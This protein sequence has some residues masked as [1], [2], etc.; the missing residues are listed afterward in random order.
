[1]TRPAKAC[2]NGVVG[3]ERA[4]R[5][6]GCREPRGQLLANRGQRGEW[7][8]AVRALPPEVA[9]AAVVARIPRRAVVGDGSDQQR[10]EGSSLNPA[11][12]AVLDREGRAQRRRRRSFDP[13]QRPQLANVA[14][15]L[16]ARQALHPS[17]RR[18]LF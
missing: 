9:A 16:Q 8:V 5:F 10:Q 3:E 1:M 12:T 14:G 2:W 15:R 13:Q 11:R 17:G 18:I 7:V 4:T 6:E